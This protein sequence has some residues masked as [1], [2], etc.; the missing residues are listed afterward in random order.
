VP[1]WRDEAVAAIDQCIAAEGRVARRPERKSLG[2]ARPEGDGW[3]MVDLRGKQVN[4]DNLDG[5]Q[6]ESSRSE[7]CYRVMEAVPQGEILRVRVARHVMARGLQLTAM[8]RSTALLLESLRDG[9]RKLTDAGGCA[10][11]L[12][13][14]RIEPVPAGSAERPPT[15]FTQGQEQAF[16]ACLTPG[17]RLVWGPPGTGKTLV[18]A[19]AIDRLLERGS[20]VLLVSGTNVAVDNALLGVVRLRRRPPGA[21]VRVGP[22]QISEVALDE[23]V[24]LPRLVAARA[25]ALERER[26]QVEYR[27]VELGSD[28]HRLSELDDALRAYD[29]GAYATARAR[30]EIGRRIHELARHLYEGTAAAA[31][32]S[33]THDGATRALHDA[34]SRWEATAPARAALDAAA[35]LRRELDDVQISVNRA[36]SARLDIELRRDAMQNHLANADSARGLAWLRTRGEAYR[37]REEVGRLDGLVRGAEHAEEAARRRAEDQR[38]RL[39][40]RIAGLEREAA[41]LDA[42]AVESLRLELEAARR[43]THETARLAEAAMRGAEATREELLTAEAQPQATDEH[44]RI[45]TEADAAGWPQLHAER[46]ELLQRQLARTPEI[47]GLERR[48]DELLQQQERMARDSE[49][50]IIGQARLVATTL[51]RFRLHP[52]VNAAPFD[53]VLVDEVGAAT[54]AEVLLPVAAARQTAVLL[55][56]FLQL[57]PVLKDEVRDSPNPLVQRW[58]SSTCFDHCG[59]RTPTEAKEHSGCAVLDVQY[60]FGPDV[61]ELAN[62]AMYASALR[63]GGERSRSALEHEVVLI[64]TD[65]LGEIGRALPGPHGRSRWWLAGSLLAPILAQHHADRGQ[66]VGLISPYRP[67]AEAMLEALHDAEGGDARP[68]TE[69]GTAHSFQGREF[70][71]VVFDLVE[72]GLW[73]GWLADRRAERMTSGSRVLNVGI[74]RCRDRLYLIGSAKLITSA[75]SP[76]RT[77]LT[78]VSEL[79]AAGR[80]HVV[81]ATAMLEVPETA[82]SATPDPMLQELADTLARYVRV[83]GIHDEHTYYRELQRHLAEARHSIWLWAPWVARRAEELLTPLRAARER[84]CRVVVFVLT[85]QDRGMETEI[86]QG[87]LARLREAATTVVQMQRMHQKIVVVDEHTVM[88]GSLNTLSSQRQREIMVIHRGAHFAAKLLEHEHAD[89]FARPPKCGRCGEQAALRRSESAVQARPWLWRCARRC[90]WEEPVRLSGERRRQAGGAA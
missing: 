66:R 36:G 46:E 73:R 9:L 51:A 33:A 11:R 5:L 52:A 7:G 31:Q 14:N 61:M 34:E 6:L 83:V 19:R 2:E 67:Q 63:A 55:G 18:L 23:S 30:M 43:H 1:D 68:M 47:R 32:T 81:K 71:I 50:E 44:R 42:T 15:G 21:L 60:R 4:P 24:S 53:V 72:D 58:V 25:A 69:A 62:R 82:M 49:R 27:L 57:G 90:G 87:Q 37:L 76:P 40:P 17:V 3:Y 39:A 88:Y 54:L 8:Q 22:P 16:H 89:V 64:D 84:G 45:V 28:G 41:A 79:L 12:V 48:H 38:R 35:G 13:Q 78:P 74:T 59:I 80:I 75:S 20:R 56:D 10:H 26:R 29:E 86:A 77:A 85:D 70:D 65:G